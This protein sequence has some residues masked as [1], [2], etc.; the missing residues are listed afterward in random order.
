MLHYSLMQIA[1]ITA[2]FFLAGMVK[3]M[4]GMGL[5]TVGMGGLGLFM[6]PVEAA[7]LLVVPTFVTNVWQLFAGPSL[8]RLATRLCL[9]LAAIMVGTIASAKLLTGGDTALTTTGLGVALALY[10]AIGL[11]AR[12]FRVPARAERWLS[13]LIGLTTGLIAGGTGV[14]TVPAVPYLQALGL[15]RDDLI[16]ALGLSFT[17][18]S[19]ALAIGLARGGA[20]HSGEFAA[21]TLAIAPA[22][23]GMWSG[24]VARKHISP[25]AFR[26]V[27]LVCLFLLGSELALRALL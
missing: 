16:Q 20:L 8:A 13:P 5:P 1:V 7:S 2:V 27:F 24:Q 17:V 25:P 4:T 11:L 18:S 6:A 21:S 12:P 9:M 22:L 19:I 26:R 10:A 15:D 23:L 3:G 14:F